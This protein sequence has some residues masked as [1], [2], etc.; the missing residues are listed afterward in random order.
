MYQNQIQSEVQLD[1]TQT[2]EKM[3]EPYKGDESPKW[4]GSAKSSGADSMQNYT[5]QTT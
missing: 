2:D 5:T 3:L 1:R 4:P